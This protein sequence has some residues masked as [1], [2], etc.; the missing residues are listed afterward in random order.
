MVPYTV[1]YKVERQG[2][3]RKWR[4][5]I[6]CR[7]RN[8]EQLARLSPKEFTTEGAAYDWGARAARRVITAG[9]NYIA[10]HSHLPGEDE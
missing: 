4:V 10:G 6:I 9:V 2:R 8:G 5:E 7:D 3:Q 1:D